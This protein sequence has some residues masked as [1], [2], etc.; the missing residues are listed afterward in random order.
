M[1]WQ[2]NRRLTEKPLVLNNRKKGA[3]KF[4]GTWSL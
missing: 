2:W 1:E 3:A 4:A